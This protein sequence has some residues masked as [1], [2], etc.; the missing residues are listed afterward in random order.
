VRAADADAA[1][2]ST[3][4]K[5][6]R[7]LT[8]LRTQVIEVPAADRDR[9]LAAYSRLPNV[10]RAT[11]AVKLS[12]AGTP[13]DPGYA[14]QWAL[15]KIGWDQAYGVVPISGTATIAVLDTGVDAT[16][17]DLSGRMALP[18]YSSLG[19]VTTGD[20]DKDPNGHGTALAG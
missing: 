14:Q 17:P 13:S 7:H 15:P 4:G 3:G 16:H 11:P 20:P 6:A 19:G 5:T 9:V 8:S 2:A 10:E 12:K 1:V 18:G